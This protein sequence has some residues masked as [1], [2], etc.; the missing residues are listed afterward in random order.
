MKLKPSIICVIVLIGCHPNVESHSIDF[1]W[2][3]CN[4]WGVNCE[5][6]T[7]YGTH[8][9]VPEMDWG[10]YYGGRDL[11]IFDDIDCSFYP[12]DCRALIFHELG[13]RQ[14]WSSK[15]IDANYWAIC[16]EGEELNNRRIMCKAMPVVCQLEN[17]DSI[18]E[19]GPY[20]RN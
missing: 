4:D 20:R 2:E 12:N 19:Q 15:E 9:K 8:D 17:C 18:V 6:Y 11:I 1:V 16:L 13:H 7:S 10:H 3:I 14:M 5:T